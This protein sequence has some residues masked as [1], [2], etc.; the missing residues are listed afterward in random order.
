MSSYKGLL[1]AL[2]L[3]L[4]AACDS[5][6]PEHTAEKPPAPPAAVQEQ[7]APADVGALAKRFA[8]REL[9]V[10][11]VSETQL[12]GSSTL[13]VTFS[14]PLDPE[15]PFAERLAQRI[16]RGDPGRKQRGQHEHQDDDRADHCERV[17]H[18]RAENP[19][20]PAEAR[21]HRRGGAVVDQPVAKCCHVRFSLA[22]TWIE[23]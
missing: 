16:M 23:H 18:Q 1:L 8:G 21:L 6:T 14:V 13:A 17:V 9:K 15:Q 11:D 2:S 19:V 22:R 7:R 12:D 20:E 3:G 4:L 10:V 5:S